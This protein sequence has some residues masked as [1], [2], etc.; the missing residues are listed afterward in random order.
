MADEG[1]L[2]IFVLAGMCVE[3]RIQKPHRVLGWLF[4][5]IMQ[6]LHDGTSYFPR[7]PLRGFDLMPKGQKRRRSCNA[8]WA[9]DFHRTRVG[10]ANSISCFDIASFCN[11][12]LLKPR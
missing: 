2:E 12:K 5:K 6:L 1:S 3:S 10:L 9:E 11:P 4:S 7:L 8:N